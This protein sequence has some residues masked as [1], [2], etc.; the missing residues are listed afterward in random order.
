MFLL[1]SHYPDFLFTSR[2]HALKN[3]VQSI[4]QGSQIENVKYQ[5]L[6]KEKSANI[7]SLENQHKFVQLDE[8][9]AQIRTFLSRCIF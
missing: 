7:S 9:S 5:L 2:I 8:N 3:Y 4:V 1:V 6:K